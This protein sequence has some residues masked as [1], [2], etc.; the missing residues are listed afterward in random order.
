LVFGLLITIIKTVLGNLKKRN[1]K[2]L[3]NI[4]GNLPIIR[5]QTILKDFLKGKPTIYKEFKRKG[6]DSN[7]NTYDTN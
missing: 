2:S 5:H 4:W 3:S 7:S 1:K 6:C